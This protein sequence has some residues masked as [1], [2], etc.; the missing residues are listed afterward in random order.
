M[1]L[2]FFVLYEVVALLCRRTR[3]LFT[4]VLLLGFLA[5][6]LVPHSLLLIHFVDL[7]LS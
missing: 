7:L 4:S 6:V 1:R 2:L 5:R 3:L